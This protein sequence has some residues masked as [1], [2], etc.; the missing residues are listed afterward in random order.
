MQFYINKSQ[1][2]KNSVAQQSFKRLTNDLLDE[3]LQDL[4]DNTCQIQ[5]NQN[6]D[7]LYLQISPKI[8]SFIYNNYQFQLDFRINYPYS[9]PLIQVESNIPHPNID[10]KNH[11]LYVKFLDPNVWKPVYGLYDIIQAIKQTILYI[12]YTYIPN[13]IQCIKSAQRMGQQDHS[14]DEEESEDKGFEL[15]ENF[16][17]NFELPTLSRISVENEQSDDTEEENQDDPS[18]RSSQ[19]PA[20]INLTKNTRHSLDDNN[21]LP[22]PKK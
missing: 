19:E 16:K 20:I 1:Q 13:D 2:E 15:S 12:D 18:E 11:Q 17:R 9:P 6:G 4:N 7:K 3:K 8:G 21:T 5:M 10:L 14:T 22:K